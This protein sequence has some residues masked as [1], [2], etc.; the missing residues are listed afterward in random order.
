VPKEASTVIAIAVGILILGTA[1]LFAVRPAI[2]SRAIVAALAIGALVMIG[3]GVAAAAHGERKTEPRA[4]EA[5]GGAAPVKIKA[6][7]VAFDKTDITLKADSDVEITFT[8]A[9]KGIQHN[10]DIFGADP[11]KSIFKGDLVTGAATMTYSFHSPAPGTY[12]FQCD[13]HPTMKGTVTVA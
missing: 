4:G 8:N 10:I 9:D 2:S 5:A 13:V 3:G 6:Q 11:T 7:S 12:N 1:S